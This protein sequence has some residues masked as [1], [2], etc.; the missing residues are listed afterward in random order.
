MPKVLP[1]EPTWPDSRVS[2]VIFCPLLLIKH[3]RS[4]GRVACLTP[5]KLSLLICKMGIIR[6]NDLMGGL[7]EVALD[8]TGIPKNSKER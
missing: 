8:L 5:P 3:S 4:V 6:R 1:F 7:N 2:M